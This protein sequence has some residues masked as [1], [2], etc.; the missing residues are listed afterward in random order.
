MQKKKQNPKPIN[1]NPQTYLLIY[2][3]KLNVR[4]IL[5][6]PHQHVRTLYKVC[7]EHRLR[8]MAIYLFNTILPF[9]LLWY[10]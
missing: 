3:E 2:T 6:I 8:D 7:G 10:H 5:L 9:F 4:Q 1:S